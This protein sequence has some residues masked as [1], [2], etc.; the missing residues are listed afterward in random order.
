MDT[1]KIQRVARYIKRLDFGQQKVDLPKL[2][3]TP[4]WKAKSK[5]SRDT[6]E[7]F[8]LGVIQFTERFPITSEPNEDLKKVI[9]PAAAYNPKAIDSM[10]HD[11]YIQGRLQLFGG[12]D[13]ITPPSNSPLQLSGVLLDSFKKILWD[14]E[15]FVYEPGIC[16]EDFQ[17]AL[18]MFWCCRLFYESISE[19]VDTIDLEALTR[20]DNAFAML[21]GL[22]GEMVE[23]CVNHSRFREKALHG[24]L[25][26]RK[27][28]NLKQM[29]VIET[30]RGMVRKPVKPYTIAGIIQKKW[31]VDPAVPKDRAPSKDTIIRYLREENLIK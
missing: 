19:L 6:L 3:Q 5:L 30:F 26:R 21:C 22:S 25:S 16:L 7:R 29:K 14:K 23:W 15:P 12:P 9:P 18:P 8:C 31:V 24:T 20:I 11:Q 1:K 27:S 10:S 17:D 2:R 4:T 28:A 13:F